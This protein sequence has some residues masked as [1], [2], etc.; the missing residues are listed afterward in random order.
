MAG[1]QE[2]LRQGQVVGIVQ[3]EQPAFVG[4]QPALNG[5]NNARLILL[6]FFPQIEQLSQRHKVSDEGLTGGCPYPEDV[7]ILVA[8]AKGV[9]GRR[10]RFADAAE[11]IEGLRLGQRRRSRSR[12]PLVKQCQQVF[13][14]REERVACNGNV[15]YAGTLRRWWHQSW[16][17]RCYA[18][19]IRWWYQ[20]KLSKRFAKHC[21]EFLAK[22]G[23][24]KGPAV[25]PATDI[26]GCRADQLG[27][28]LLRPSAL[29]ACLA[30]AKIRGELLVFFHPC[31]P[32]II[33]LCAFCEWE[34]KKRVQAV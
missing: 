6:I 8:V 20:T 18:G 29:I 7:G 17:S 25:F 10:L 31:L 27:E 4:S 14:T 12:E 23:R 16:L 2:L 33:C 3:D 22:I 15:P 19:I 13:A 32:Y 34:K 26:D 1:G 5:G 11:S 24:R 9:F 30:Q 28:I 21:T